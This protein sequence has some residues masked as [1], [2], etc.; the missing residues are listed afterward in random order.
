MTAP[1][2]GSPRTSAERA[3]PEMVR[4]QSELILDAPFLRKLYDA[5]AETVLIVNRQRQI[6]FC[7]RA[8]MQLLDLE[9]RSEAYGLRPGEALRCVRA[10]EGESGCG[11]TEFCRTCGAARALATARAGD[12]DAEECRV[13]RE[14]EALDLYVR[15]TPLELTGEQFTIFALRD[16]S[17]QKRRR[18]LERTFFHDLM[19]TAMGLKVLSRRLSARADGEVEE[20]AARICQA[21]G[22]L[23]DEL[24][25]QRDLSAAES[26]EL[27]VNPAPIDS[28]KLLAE[29][30]E[31]HAP[32]ADSS[33]CR[34][35][36][37]ERT[38]N[39]SLKSDRRLLSRVLGNM[40]KNAVE[41]SQPGQTVTMGACR[42]DGKVCFWVHNEAFIPREVQLQLFQR[43]F[44][45]KEPGRGL[46]TYSMK[47]LTERYLDGELY[48]STSRENGTTFTACYPLEVEPG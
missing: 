21:V 18:A 37:D 4:E 22:R 5:V 1:A 6:V 13:L 14:T 42:E 35:K 17:H 25:G 34:L 12:A 40:V 26:G 36:V 23:L 2:Q 41:A 32:L 31:A 39:V 47:L 7:N 10:L 8:G 19:N 20:L 27:P 24:C 15:S 3:A 33:D 38:E 16:I 9:D 43:S 30:K 46:G 29:V 28:G 48:F 44:S 45:T 11:T